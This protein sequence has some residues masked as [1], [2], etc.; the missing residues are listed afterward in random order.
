MVTDAYLCDTY[1]LSD[2]LH[3]MPLIAEIV[4]D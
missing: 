3:K 2:R 1:I 4:E